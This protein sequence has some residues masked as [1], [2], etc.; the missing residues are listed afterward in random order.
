MMLRTIRLEI[1]RSVAIYSDV[2]FLGEKIRGGCLEEGTVCLDCPNLRAN[3]GLQNVLVSEWMKWLPDA[4][5]ADQW[6]NYASVVNLLLS[7][8]KRLTLAGTSP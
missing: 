5:A 1:E 3:V 6:V 2:V 4:F 8:I 7:A